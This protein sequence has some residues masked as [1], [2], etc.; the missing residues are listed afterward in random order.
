MTTF[1]SYFK[2]KLQA[3]CLYFKITAPSKPI[4]RIEYKPSTMDY[5]LSGTAVIFPLSEFVTITPAKVTVLYILI[6]DKNLA[7]DECSISNYILLPDCTDGEQLFMQTLTMLESSRVID[8]AYTVISHELFNNAKIKTLLEITAEL[9]GNPIFLSDTSTKMLEASDVNELAQINDELITCVLRNGF[10]TSD[11]FEKYDYANLLK[12]IAQSEKAFFLESP[13][14]EKRNRIIANIMVNNHQFGWLVAIPNRDIFKFEH[15]EIMDILGHAISIELERSKTS[16]AINSSENLLLDLLTGQFAS[17]E[18]FGRRACGFGWSLNN[19]YNTIVIG[20]RDPTDNNT[21]IGIRSMMAYKNHLSL[22]FPSVKSIY[23]K[24]HLVL[25]LESKVH[26]QIL[27]N[28]E[29]FLTNYNLIASVSNHFSNI[30]DFKEYY[31]QAVDIL[32]LGLRLN[33][34]NNIF[35]YHDL[36]LYHCIDTLKKAGHLEYYCLPEL[37]QV[38]QYDKKYN[39]NFAETVQAYLKFRNIANTAE[40]LEIHR[41]TMIYRLEKFKVLTNLNLSNG[42][43]IYK[44]WLSFLILEVSPNLVDG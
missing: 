41:N 14:P 31:N 10:V 20:Y 39:T 16:L 3:N 17:A 24:E 35:Y 40:H 28:L 2:E 30:I 12:T 23:I 22:I 32:N 26:S 19:C 4:V 13:I 8:S 18:D 43:D 38:I 11:L 34:E 27:N 37:L 25:L 36:Y 5:L 1:E 15:C 7:F 6:K 21:Q 44:L 33:M 42:D 9:I 29:I